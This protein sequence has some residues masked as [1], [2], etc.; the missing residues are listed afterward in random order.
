MGTAGCL[1]NLEKFN[2][3]NFLIIY[4]DLIFNIDLRKFIKF[5]LQKKSHLSF[6]VHP[7]DHPSDSD[8]VEVD[9]DFKII[10]LH[11]NPHKKENIGNLCISG[12]SIIN[13]EIL[14]QEKFYGN[15]YF[16]RW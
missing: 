2:F 14:K 8:I 7:S 6:L 13:K 9:K 15:C 16:N 3:E 10:K 5:H 1:K 11:K 12:I 4:G